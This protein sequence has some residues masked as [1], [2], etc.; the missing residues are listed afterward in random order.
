MKIYTNECGRVI[1]VNTPAEGAREIDITEDEAFCGFSETR[2]LCYFYEGAGTFYPA[3]D[4][5]T[6][7]LLERRQE[8]AERLDSLTDLLIISSLEG[9]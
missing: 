1:S 2:M 9:K 5:D 7:A 8:E 3:L 4:L 6:I